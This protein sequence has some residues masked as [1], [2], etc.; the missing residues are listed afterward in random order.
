[1]QSDDVISDFAEFCVVRELDPVEVLKVLS[2]QDWH[3]AD[4]EPGY[5]MQPLTIH[6][7]FA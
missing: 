4:E 5:T 1:M 6:G 2:A 3:P 7:D